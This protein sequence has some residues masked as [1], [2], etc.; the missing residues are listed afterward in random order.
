MGEGLDPSGGGVGTTTCHLSPA[1]RL[2]ACVRVFPTDTPLQHRLYVSH[3]DM[4]Q[5]CSTGCVSIIQIYMFLIQ[6]S[7]LP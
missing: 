7:E 4:T 3:T 1:A 6:T 2:Q 5:D